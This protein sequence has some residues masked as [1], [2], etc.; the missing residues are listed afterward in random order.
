M[1]K[2]GTFAD[3]R[4]SGG[5]GKDTLV[6]LTGSD[7][8]MGGRGNDHLWGYTDGWAGHAPP[9]WDNGADTFVYRMDRGRGSDGHDTIHM[10]DPAHDDTLLLVDRFGKVTS[11]AQLEGR[12]TVSNGDPNNF[13]TR[14]DVTIAFKDG[15]G[16]ITLDNLFA[17]GASPA[18]IDSLADLAQHIAIEVARD[19]D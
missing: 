17:P 4:V 10:V 19:W 6:G 9:G 13:D 3:D 18:E 12:V 7:T 5:N 15:S 14:G 16:S 11:L 8:L 2:A 1:R